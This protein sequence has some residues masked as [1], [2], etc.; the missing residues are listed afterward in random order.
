MNAVTSTTT[1][2][3]IAWRRELQISRVGRGYNVV[4]RNV[5]MTPVLASI[6]CTSLA[7]SNAVV[8]HLEH[9]QLA[10]SNDDQHGS[11]LARFDLTAEEAK[12]IADWAG[13]DMPRPLALLS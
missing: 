6:T 8:Q 5:G 11:A 4:V 1:M 12:R 3:L 10:A 2:S 9:F 13:L 7:L